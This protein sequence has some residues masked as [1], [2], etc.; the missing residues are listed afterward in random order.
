MSARS[1]LRTYLVR[2]SNRGPT[3]VLV[4]GAVLVCAALV[5]GVGPF[6][7]ITLD[8]AEHALLQERPQIALQRCESL[9]RWGLLDSWRDRA[10][11]R[12]ASI[13]ARHMGQPGRAARSLRGLLDD[14]VRDPGLETLSLQLL[15]ESLETL[16]R[17][18]RAAEAYERLA[19]RSEHP[20][21]ALQAAARS[22]E[23]A[24]HPERALL[25][26]AQRLVLAPEHSSEALL[27][28]GRI[29]LGLGRADKAYDYWARTREADPST[30]RDRLARLGMAMALEEL[31]RSE[32]A[33]AELDEP[34]PSRD[35][36]IDITRARLQRRAEEELGTP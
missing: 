1:R 27:A 17:F 13:R 33:L 23:H 29:S 10:R 36:A 25:L 35:R 5:L 6:T 14:G 21:A 4:A 3:A 32:Q 34:A 11:Y 19:R 16:G 24:G 9:S 2:I 12:A 20:A 22:W 26:Q 8:R 30:E 18:H 28:M 15:G 7:P 31:G